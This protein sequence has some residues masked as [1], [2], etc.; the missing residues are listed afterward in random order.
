MI[1]L[2]ILAGYG[3]PENDIPCPNFC[4]NECGPGSM[5][6][7]GGKDPNGCKN[8][9]ICVPTKSPRKP[10]LTARAEFKLI[11]ILVCS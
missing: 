8:P 9:E 7:C 4:P 10:F 11:F 1:L 3:G 5:S 6:C 2:T